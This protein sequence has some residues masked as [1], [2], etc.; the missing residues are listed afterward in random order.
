MDT[1]YATGHSGLVGGSPTNGGLLDSD[2]L[3][4]ANALENA[5]LCSQGCVATPGCTH[6]TL[7]PVGS[8]TQCILRTTN[9]PAVPKENGISGPAGAAARYTASL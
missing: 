7:M 9:A 1:N 6:W 5:A 8:T 2:L 3:T 4:G